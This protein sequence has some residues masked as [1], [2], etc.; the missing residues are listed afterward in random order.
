MFWFF[1]A[2][3]ATNQ[4]V[5]LD[6]RIQAAMVAD[7][8]TILRQYIADDFRFTHADSTVETKVGVLRAAAMRPRH[9]LRRRVVHAAAEIHGRIGLV[10]GN[11]D[12]ATGPTSEDPPGTQAVCYS[13]NY[14]HV[15]EKRAGRWQ[16]LTHR[17]TQMTEPERPCTPSR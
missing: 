15:Y 5:V 10:F 13:L 1:T 11:L 7:Q 8:E 9:Y 14:V 3:L 2:A 16:L 6:R 4:L 12:V 17:T